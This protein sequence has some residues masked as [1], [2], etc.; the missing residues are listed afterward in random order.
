MTNF[1]LRQDK[2]Q[3]IF[4]ISPLQFRNIWLPII[5]LLAGHFLSNRGKE[6]HL[7]Q[8]SK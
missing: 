1:R 3:T 6:A 7:K 4:L 8:I 5:T 2:S